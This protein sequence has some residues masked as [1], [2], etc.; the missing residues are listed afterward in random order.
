[1]QRVFFLLSSLIVMYLDLYS[2]QFFSHLLQEKNI[3]I[4]KDFMLKLQYNEGIAFSI[5]LKGILQIIISVIVLIIL[6][7]YNQKEYKFKNWISTIAISFI[8]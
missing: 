7:T 3:T 6:I 8:T 4:F 5:P 2:K 1:M